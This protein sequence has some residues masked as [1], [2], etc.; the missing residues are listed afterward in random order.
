MQKAYSPRS[1]L[2]AQCS[3][4]V[5]IIMSSY[6]RTFLSICGGVLLLTN[7]VQAD[8]LESTVLAYDRVANI[9]VIKDKTVW[10]LDLLKS[11]LPENLRAGDK[12]EI[13]YTSN[14]DDGIRTITSIARLD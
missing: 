11:P 13:L 8:S 9:I 7:P 2:G 12:I 5:A 6:I 10:D 1:L 4:R 14:E 3:L